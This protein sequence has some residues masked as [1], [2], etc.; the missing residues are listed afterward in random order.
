MAAPNKRFFGVPLQELSDRQSQKGIPT[1][2]KDLIRCLNSDE[3]LE[4]EG[5]FRR[6][7]N[8]AALSELR[9]RIEEGIY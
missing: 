3:A 4:K 2:F 8:V 6:T 5:I 9:T 1:L 7:A